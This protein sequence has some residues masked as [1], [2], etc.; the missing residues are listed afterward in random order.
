MLIYIN[1]LKHV[2]HVFLFVAYYAH[3]RIQ[4]LAATQRC[5]NDSFIEDSAAVE[6]RQLLALTWDGRTYE[7]YS[8]QCY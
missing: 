6:I 7:M 3:V 2:K 8:L 4:L 1:C 5:L